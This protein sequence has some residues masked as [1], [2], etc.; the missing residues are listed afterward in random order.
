MYIYI[1]TYQCIYVSIPVNVGSWP[2]HERRMKLLIRN[3]HGQSA[4]SPI[5]CEGFHINMNLHEPPKHV[6]KTIHKIK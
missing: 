2:P 5:D 3:G 4:W 1:Y 6:G